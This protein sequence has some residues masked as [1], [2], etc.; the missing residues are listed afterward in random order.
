MAIK[1][2]KGDPIHSEL[3]IDNKSYS[4]DYYSA[5]TRIAD[6]L[7]TDSTVQLLHEGL[8]QE[9]SRETWIFKEFDIKKELVFQVIDA[10]EEGVAYDVKGILLSQVV[11]FGIHNPDKE[12][13]SK[14]NAKQ[15]QVMQKLPSDIRPQ[16]YDPC[17]LLKALH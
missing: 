10:F 17:S 2:Y 14:L 11:P 4:V 7:I 8:L 5:K 16:M 12:F 13:C 6:V 15:W 9:Y 1:L 3:F